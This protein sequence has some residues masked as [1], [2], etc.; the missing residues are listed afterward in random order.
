M[1]L[2][3][4]G[5]YFTVLVS[6]TDNGG[7]HGKR[8]WRGRLL[9]QVVSELCPLFLCDIYPIDAAELVVRSQTLMP[10]EQLV[11]GWLYDDREIWEIEFREMYARLEAAR[12]AAREA[13][14]KAL[15]AQAK[16]HAA[17]LRAAKRQGLVVIDPTELFRAPEP[18]PTSEESE[19]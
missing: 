11:Q 7:N 10:L 5:K 6:D 4:S 12:E 1:I 15:R 17:M 19:P 13:A 16:K 8:L 9:G 3:L 18:E 2:P 14:E